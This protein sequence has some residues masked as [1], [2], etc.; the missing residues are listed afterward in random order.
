[1]AITGIVLG[2]NDRYYTATI[3]PS[4]VPPGGAPTN[5]NLTLTNNILSGPSHFLRQIIVTVPTGFT[6]TGPVTVQAPAGAPLPWKATVSGQTVTVV[7][8]SSSDSS[9]IA[10]QSVIITVPAI[11]PSVP[12]PGKSYTWAIS[13][14]QAIG[15]GTGNAYNPTPGSPAPVVKVGCDTQ[16]NLALSISPDS[17]ITTDTSAMVTLTGLLKR[18]DTNS[19]LSGELIKFELGG[20]PVTCNGG[21]SYTNAAGVATCS[22]TPQANLS[23][24]LPSGVYDIFAKFAGDSSTSPALGSSVAGPEKLNVNATGTGLDVASLN[25]DYNPSPRPVTLTAT[26]TALGSPLSGK[27]VSFMLGPDTMGSATTDGSGVATLNTTLPVLTPGTTIGYIKG[28][29][30]GDGV[31]ASANGAGDVTIGKIPGTIWFDTAS[32]TKTYTGL[33]LSPTVITNPPG[34]SFSFTG[35]SQTNAGSYPVTAT[36]TD[37]SYSGTASAT[38]TINPAMPTITVTGYNVPYDTLSHSL[39]TGVAI[40]AQGEDLSAALVLTGTTHINAGSYLD[41]WTFG[42]TANYQYA[43][44]NVLDVI[45]KASSSVTV[46]GGTFTYNGSAHPATGVASTTVGSLAL[47]ATVTISYSGS[48]S[49]APVTVAQGTSCTATG[50]YA[51][52]SNHEGSTGTATITINKA[53]QTITF[54]SIV[55]SA[56]AGGTVTFSSGTPGICSVTPLSAGQATVTLASGATWAQCQILANQG[57]TSDYNAAP[58]ETGVFTVTP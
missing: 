38:F 56:T 52:D 22:F 27:S 36:I 55:V 50:T 41:T 28:T 11:P 24:A 23:T 43:S 25:L 45:T 5:F 32:L 9:V 14:N 54:N 1:M 48:C 19:P 53:D 51:G 15:G 2:A 35:Y 42:P 6:I 12:C 47:P 29:F 7:S 21:P 34:L 4:D 26:L 57:G 18:N 31:Y 40:G 10:G 30:A 13:A 39:S 44:G 46:T 37:P 8:G 20:Q 58:T 3:G 16:T 17:I 33:A 49:S